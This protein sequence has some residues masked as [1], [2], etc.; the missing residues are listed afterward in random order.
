MKLY[1]DPCHHRSICFW[2]SE[3]MKFI[4]FY[5][6]SII[7]RWVL[8]SMVAWKKTHLC[9][10]QYC[11][12]LFHCQHLFSF[13][14]FLF[15]RTRFLVTGNVGDCLGSKLRFK[16]LCIT[17]WQCIYEA[18]ISF[19]YILSCNPNALYEVTSQQPKF[20]TRSV[21]NRRNLWIKARQPRKH[22]L[23]D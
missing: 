13:F 6:I 10:K 3:I 16:P 23:K 22:C 20:L 9:F 2:H 19:L 5:N 18:L 17:T 4:F 8:N 11:L 12:G 7:V 15:F 14:L 21:P 1:F